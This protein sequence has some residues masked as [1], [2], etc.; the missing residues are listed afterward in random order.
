MKIF[1]SK[2]VS[3]TI[4]PGGWG[5]ILVFIFSKIDSFK[6][7]TL[8][9]FYHLWDVNSCQEET[10]FWYLS[11]ILSQCLEFLFMNFETIF[12]W[13]IV[14]QY[15]V[16]TVLNKT[17]EC[18]ILLKLKYFPWRIFQKIQLYLEHVM[19]CFIA[20]KILRTFSEWIISGESFFEF[21]YLYLLFHSNDKI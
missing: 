4:C 2:Q 15:E 17:C 18:S 3:L 5:Y 16:C 12:Y 8:H 10:K 9:R 1:D 19:D 21:R 14:L 6:V 7:T 11:N 13:E 20:K